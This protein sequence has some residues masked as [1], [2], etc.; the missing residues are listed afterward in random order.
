MAVPQLGLP[1]LAPRRLWLTVLSWK[2]VKYGQTEVT[3]HESTG[4]LGR[5]IVKTSSLDARKSRVRVSLMSMSNA[6]TAVRTDSPRS[7]PKTFF[8][9]D[10]LPKDDTL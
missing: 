3:F 7:A 6:W 4:V 9:L 1:P 10:R 5:A 2:P 8:F